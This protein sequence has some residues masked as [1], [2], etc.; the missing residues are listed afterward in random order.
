[1]YTEPCISVWNCNVQK[2]TTGSQ[3]LFMYIVAYVGGGPQVPKQMSR[4]CTSAYIYMVSPVSSLS[5]VWT[6][7]GS[8]ISYDKCRV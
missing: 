6:E 5:V 1:M 3:H 2:Y 7:R 4:L 8:S